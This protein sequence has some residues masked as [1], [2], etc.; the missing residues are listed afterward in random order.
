M[1][2]ECGLSNKISFYGQNRIKADIKTL[3]ISIY[4]SVDLKHMEYRKNNHFE[5]KMNDN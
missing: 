3:S 1:K 4:F 2:E 5:L